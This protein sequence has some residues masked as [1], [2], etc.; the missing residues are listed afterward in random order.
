M[1]SLYIV[2]VYDIG[3][4]KLDQCV[5][6]SLGCNDMETQ[7]RSIEVNNG[8]KLLVWMRHHEECVK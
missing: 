1:E 2:V 3:F 4:H 7:C 5:F 6:V 8:A